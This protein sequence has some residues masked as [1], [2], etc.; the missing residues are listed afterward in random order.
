MTQIK[1]EGIRIGAFHVALVIKNLP[2]KEQVK[3]PVNARR[4]MRHGFDP[5]LGRSS[6]GGNG[7]PVFL[8]GE[9][10]G[11][12]SLVGYCPQAHRVGHN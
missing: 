5:G 1:R 7:N 2:G 12:K 9:F 8:P 11:Q 6:G 10:H 3:N 4:H